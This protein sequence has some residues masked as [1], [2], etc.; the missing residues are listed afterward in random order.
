MGLDEK[1]SFEEENEYVDVEYGDSEIIMYDGWNETHGI[2]FEISA[3]I[4]GKIVI[5]LNETLAFE[6]E[7]TA[8]DSDD[9]DGSLVF[10][11]WKED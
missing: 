8:D 6:K 9:Y 2:E 4:D 5:Y 10:R 7:L 1:I 3:E 11:H